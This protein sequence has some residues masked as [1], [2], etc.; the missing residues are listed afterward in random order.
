MAA[1]PFVYSL[2]LRQVIELIIEG[3]GINRHG[4][5]EDMQLFIKL[6]WKDPEECDTEISRM[7]KC[8]F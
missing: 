2:Q 7:E 5:A 8:F 3:H 6:T 1:A 4:Y